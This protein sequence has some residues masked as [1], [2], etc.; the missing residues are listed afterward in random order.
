M[1]SVKAKNSIKIVPGDRSQE[2][3]E[4]GKV[5]ILREFEPIETGVPFWVGVGLAE[6]SQLN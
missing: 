4:G 1:I 3:F 5:R 6:A 2:C